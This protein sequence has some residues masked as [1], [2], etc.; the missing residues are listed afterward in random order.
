MRPFFAAL[1][2]SALMLPVAKAELFDYRYDYGPR[3]G[4]IDRL[5][6]DYVNTSNGGRCSIFRSG[7]GFEF[8]NENGDRATFNYVGP[9]RLG[10]VRTRN[11]DPSTVATVG[12]DR[13]GRVQIRFDSPR[14]APGYWVS[15]Y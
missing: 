5:A 9:G 2:L 13:L 3:S 1:L 15:A 8:V 11:W 6:G 12:Y 14:S 7:R 10:I 4:T